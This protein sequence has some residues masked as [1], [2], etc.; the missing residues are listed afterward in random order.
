MTM[1]TVRKHSWRGEFRY[2]WQGELITRTPEELVILA[3]WQGPG[4]PRVGEI[5][6]RRGDRFLEHYYP[7]RGFA[8]WQLET[9]EG[10]VKGWYCNISTPITEHDDVLSFE[11]LLLD[12]LVYPDG[13]YAVLDRD[14]FAA[15]RSAGLT[16]AQAAV[17]EDALAAVLAW[18]AAAQPPFAFS[19]VPRRIETDE[20]EGATGLPR[21]RP[22]PADPLLRAEGEV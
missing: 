8:I 14:E 18:I 16:D 12:V 2:A 1:I 15:A 20:E 3:T 21:V 4:E 11:D 19:G 5:A 10:R 9:P 22:D 6:F 17:A 13:R 7:G